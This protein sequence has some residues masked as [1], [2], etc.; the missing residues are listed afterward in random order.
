[1]RRRYYPCVSLIKAGSHIPDAQ[2]RDGYDT[3]T[4]NQYKSSRILD[5]ITGTI[6]VLW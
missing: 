3:V 4:V 2:Y 6:E 5:M 1:M